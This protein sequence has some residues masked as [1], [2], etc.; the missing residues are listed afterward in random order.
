M[1]TKSFPMSTPLQPNINMLHITMYI[2]AMWWSSYTAKCILRQETFLLFS[3]G[4]VTVNSSSILDFYNSTWSILI[5]WIRFM[6]VWWQSDL[7]I[8]KEGIL[9]VCDK[10]YH[11]NKR[12]VQ[13]EEESAVLQNCTLVKQKHNGLC[14]DC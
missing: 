3:T 11:M 5:Q 1:Y 6:I 13:K 8:T 14:Q 9:P 10:P 4:T 2:I 7:V 12:K